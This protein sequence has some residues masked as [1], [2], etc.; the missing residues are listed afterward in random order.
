MTERW[1]DKGGVT[2]STSVW[3]VHK[4]DTNKVAKFLTK[5][6]KRISKLEE[7]RVL[8]EE[9]KKEEGKEEKEEETK[10]EGE[11]KTKEE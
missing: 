10:P 11:E 1:R 2:E 9:E 8:Q 5:L 7:V 3:D 6:E 4:L